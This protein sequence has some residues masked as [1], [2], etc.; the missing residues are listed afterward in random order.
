MDL[1]VVNNGGNHIMC[2]S[3]VL[4]DKYLTKYT[5]AKIKTKNT[6]ANV[7]YSVLVVKMV[8]RT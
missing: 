5:F 8:D 3:K 6:F 2:T 1:L 7:A 4:T